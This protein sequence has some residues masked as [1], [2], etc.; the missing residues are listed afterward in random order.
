M[1]F[2]PLSSFSLPCSPYPSFCRM[3]IIDGSRMHFSRVACM[4]LPAGLG[5]RARAARDGE[6]DGRVVARCSSCCL[7]RRPNLHLDPTRLSPLPV[8]PPAPPLPDLRHGAYSCSSRLLLAGLAGPTLTVPAPIPS[9]ARGHCCPPVD[10]PRATCLPCSNN[11][12]VRPLCTR[13]VL[14]LC[15][16]SIRQSACAYLIFRLPLRLGTRS[17]PAFVPLIQAR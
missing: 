9:T 8:A 1:P 7:A 11:A 16:P 12:L 2:R 6:K 14:S 15:R 4:T 17:R 3:R 5:R 13:I 10:G